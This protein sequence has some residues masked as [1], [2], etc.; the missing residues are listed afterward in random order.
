MATKAA[1][2]EEAARAVR[3]AL[4]PAIQGGKQLADHLQEAK[5]EVFTLQVVEYPADIH[6]YDGLL[7][8]ASEQ[9]DSPEPVVL[10]AE[11]FAGP[12]A[13]KYA[14]Q[15]PERVRGVVLAAG[16]ILPPKPRWL[17]FLPMRTLFTLSRPRS[18][19]RLVLTNGVEDEA[20]VE[21]IYQVGQDLSP[22]L[23]AARVRTM[24][25]ADAARDLHRYRG[26]LLYLAAS[27]DRLVGRRSL[28]EIRRVRPDV[29]VTE[30]DAPHLLLE[31]HPRNVWKAISQ[32]IN[33][34]V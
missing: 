23:M 16:F 30:I 32:F 1:A 9:L 19:I 25:C 24:L 10:L 17:R 21:Q 3:V 26:P 7:P 20:L 28:D 15:H 4:L 29:A 8:F 12:L 5:P 2:P 6:G 11:S 27:N 18:I 31:T 34:K 14:A 33:L 13:I 22:K